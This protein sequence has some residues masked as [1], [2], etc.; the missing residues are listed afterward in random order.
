MELYIVVMQISEIGIPE[1]ASTS[2]ISGNSLR[3][4]CQIFK[5]FEICRKGVQWLSQR[6]LYMPKHIYIP[7]F[8]TAFR[9]LKQFNSR[10]KE[11]KIKLIYDSDLHFCLVLCYLSTLTIKK[12]NQLINI[13]W[14]KCVIN[15]NI[16]SKKVSFPAFWFHPGVHL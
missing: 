2:I 5:N 15:L 11:A 12:G 7:N 1:C 16:L 6:C 13:F 3:Q 10:A 4:G 9:N 8:Q 14:F